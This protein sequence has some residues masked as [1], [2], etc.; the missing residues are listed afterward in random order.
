MH[1]F[2][3]S[4]IG[5]NQFIMLCREVGAEP[6]ITLNLFRD[7]PEESRAFLEYTNG[8]ADTEW[9]AERIKQGYAEPF[10]V[11]HWSLGNEMGYGHMDG[12]NDIESYTWKALA[13]AL[14]MKKAD[15][16]IELCC[17]GAYPDEAWVGESQTKLNHVA[18]YVSYHSYY[19]LK[20]PSRMKF[21]GEAETREACGM[22]TS[23]PYM[24]LQAIVCLRQRLDAQQM[25]KFAQISFDEWN[26]WD[27][28]FRTPSPGEGLFTGIMLNNV[29]RFSALCGIPICCYFQPINEGAIAVNP[30]GVRLT[31]AG[32][33][34]ELYKRHHSGRVIALE[35][36][37]PGVL[38]DAEKALDDM[39]KND[40]DML[41]SYDE[42]TETIAITCVNKRPYD[43]PLDFA[44]DGFGGTEMAEL[45]E[46]YAEG[47]TP[48]YELQRQT[49]P[50]D[51]KG[52]G[53]TVR[54]Y[55]LLQVCVKTG[56]PC[57]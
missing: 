6:F 14:E 22:L 28:W 20:L 10:N 30:S 7:T 55:S 26:V 8:G 2:D 48:G 36:F 56:L 11:K 49:L 41:A 44:F 3:N 52:K 5:I 17:S 16:D 45:C 34:F 37:E 40:L 47:V 29:I 27:A 21:T 46:L 23:A 31:N 38:A 9:G 4:E 25:E 32:I 57:A 51:A 12:P 13:T 15:P 24:T 1:G 18:P 43:I 33:V 54:R 42:A 53:V 50:V 35:G 19:P 39:C